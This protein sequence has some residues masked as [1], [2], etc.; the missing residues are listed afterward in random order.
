MLLSS[1]YKTDN[2]PSSILTELNLGDRCLDGVLSNN[3]YESDILKVPGFACRCVLDEGQEEASSELVS[4][5]NDSFCIFW[6]VLPLSFCT[7]LMYVCFPHTPKNQYLLYAHHIMN[8]QELLPMA[9]TPAL[10]HAEVFWGQGR[11][12]AGS[13]VEPGPL[14]DSSFLTVFLPMF[15]KLAWLLECQCVM[16][17]SVSC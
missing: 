15:R 13:W 11:G 3:N 16:C 17:M 5:V 12:Q 6:L 2:V 10:P 7:P 14:S 4:S 1:V 9:P 8:P